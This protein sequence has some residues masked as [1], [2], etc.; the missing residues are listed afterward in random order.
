MDVTKD[1]RFN[2]L[3]GS[4]NTRNLLNKTKGDKVIWALVVL[5]A[6]V[7][8]LAVYSA[9]G[10]LA[11]KNYKGNT[12]VYLF[13]QVAFIMVGILVIYFA[14][15][16][17]YT[18]YSRIA[19]I[20]F[21]LVIPLLI[22]TLFFGVRMNEGSRW[23]RLPLINMTMQTSDLAKL[24]LFMYI[25]RM[26]SRKQDV[27]KSFKKGYLPVITPVF[28]ICALIAPANLSTALLLGASCLLL[29]FIGRA[30][31][32]HILLTM[33]LALIP[34]AFLIIAAM[35]R[36]KQGDDEATAEKKTA[37]SGLFARVDTWIGRVE[38]FIY[39]SKEAD[40]DEMYQVNQAKIAI[41]KGGVLGVGPGNSTTRDY[42]PQAYNDFIFAIIIEE[43]GFVGGIFIVFIYLVFLYRCIRIFKRCPYAFGA[44]LALGLSFTLAIQAIANMAVTVNLFPVT[45]VT[46]PLVS[47]G[48]S[49]FIFTCLAI[50]II[51]SVARNVEQLEGR[52]AM[53]KDEEQ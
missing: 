52:V 25:A 19:T 33:G 2:E 21:L 50:G 26:L 22:Y 28:I 41:A 36:H 49:S 40:N 12:E 10:S 53:A 35:V 37:S 31:S 27:I 24:A 44:F 38:N 43:Y 1:I 9:T 29:L 30:S 8:L 17:N 34:I 11:Y 47:M 46:L 18:L 15:L 23:I 16:V 4:F 3:G 51:L 14:H 39:S 13:K 7:S 32:K 45:G 5:L 6:L 42:L 20:L 48:G